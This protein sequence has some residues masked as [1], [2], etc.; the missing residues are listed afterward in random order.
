MAYEKSHTGYMGLPSP[1]DIYCSRRRYCC[2]KIKPPLITECSHSQTN[3]EE[4][5]SWNRLSDLLR[6]SS[7]ELAQKVMA[8]QLLLDERETAL[9]NLS[10]RVKN[11]EHTHQQQKQQLEYA[12][13]KRQRHMEQVS[14][15][16]VCLRLS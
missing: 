9:T 11:S 16:S 5:K 13:S 15:H 4:N 7:A 6:Y 2:A 14:A 3:A 10:S 12:M 8:L 1:L